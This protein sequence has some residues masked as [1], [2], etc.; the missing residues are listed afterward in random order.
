MEKTDQQVLHHLAEQVFAP[1]RMQIMMTALR[2]RVRTSKDTQQEQINELNR[3]LKQTEE[4][5]HRLLKAI[6]TG[7][8]DLDET[9]KSRANSLKA[10]REAL[11]IVIAGVHRDDSRPVKHIKASQI[12]AFAKTLKDKLLAKDSTIAKT[13]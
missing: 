3:Q 9:V 1:Q 5:Q 4:R 12:E 10:A 11:L 7:I 13:T 6:E 8:I 2:Q